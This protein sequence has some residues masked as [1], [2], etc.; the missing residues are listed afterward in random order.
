MCKVTAIEG[1]NIEIVTGCLQCPGRHGVNGS[2]WSE[3]SSYPAGNGNK[4]S[5][6]FLGKGFINETL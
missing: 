4:K 3:N 6:F 5:L 1:N 2:N